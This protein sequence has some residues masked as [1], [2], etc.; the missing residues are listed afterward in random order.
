MLRRRRIQRKTQQRLQ[1]HFG[2]R[3]RKTFAPRTRLR[4]CKSSTSYFTSLIHQLLVI[5]LRFNNIF[6]QPNWRRHV[7][8]EAHSKSPCSCRRHREWWCWGDYAAE[9][10]GWVHDD[11]TNLGGGKLKWSDFKWREKVCIYM[12][13]NEWVWNVEKRRLFPWNKSKVWCAIICILQAIHDSF[14]VSLLFVPQH[15]KL[16]TACNAITFQFLFSI[17]YFYFYF[18]HFWSFNCERCFILVPKFL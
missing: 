1:R 17:I 11:I 7:P 16:I 15:V 6:K 8:S 14:W 18:L 5:T 2:V 4:S 3:R 12:R 10:G 13:I 9:E